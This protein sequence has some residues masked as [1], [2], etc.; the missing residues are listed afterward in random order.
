MSASILDMFQ[1]AAPT[2]AERDESSNREDPIKVFREAVNA[3]LAIDAAATR[4]Q[5]SRKRAQKIAAKLD[6]PNVQG[7]QEQRAAAESAV[8]ALNFE[9]NQATKEEIPRLA[10]RL[11][12]HWPNLLKSDRDWFQSVFVAGWSTSPA[13]SVLDNDPVLSKDKVIRDLIVRSNRVEVEEPPF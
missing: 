10:R 13:W 12:K 3:L 2:K 9:S 1:V 8:Y 11:L 6:D 5:A 7:T 4:A